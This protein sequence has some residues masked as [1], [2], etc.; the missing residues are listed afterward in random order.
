MSDASQGG[1][2]VQGAAIEDYLSELTDVPA[3]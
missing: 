3:A 1:G 2:Q